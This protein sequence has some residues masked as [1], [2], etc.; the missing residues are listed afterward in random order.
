[1]RLV[2]GVI[3]L[4]LGLTAGAAGEYWYAPRPHVVAPPGA[5]NIAAAA[6]RKILYYRDPGGAPHWSAT[7]KKDTAGRDYVPTRSQLSALA[8]S[9][10]NQR[11]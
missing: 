2:S 4:A 11:E 7:P 8:A 10:K 9:S 5:T 1:M 6:D 3:I